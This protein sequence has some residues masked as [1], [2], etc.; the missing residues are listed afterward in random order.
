MDKYLAAFAAFPKANTDF[1]Q[2]IVAY[3]PDFE[4]AWEATSS[5]LNRAGIKENQLNDFVD[6][7]SKTTPEREVEKLN[8][9]GIRVIPLTSEEYPKNLKEIYNPPFVIFVRGELRPEDELAIAVVGARKFTDYGRRATFEITEG[10][11]KAGVTIISGLALGLDAEAH[12]AVLK[13]GGRTIAVLANGL[14]RICPVTN[15]AIGMEILK[16]GGAIISEQPIGTPVFKQNFPARNRIIS[17]LSQGVLIAEAGEKSGTLHTANF[18]IEQNRQVYAVPGPIYNPLSAG[19]NNLI[20]VGA[21]PVSEAKDILDDL[22][23]DG[24]LKESPLPANENEVM[25]FEVLA[26]EPKHID[27]ITKESKR[28]SHEISQILTLM[29]IKGKVRHLG[30]MV[31]TLKR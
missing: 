19:P 9:F 2:K 28:P 17:G 15:H 22:G 21:K 26:T 6:F 4:K 14:D 20:K 12:K 31:Y 10:V 27:A 16:S 11:A 29:E 13:V 24:E 3:F 5:E 8:H 25:I 23:I 30:G 7:R 1:W 18:A